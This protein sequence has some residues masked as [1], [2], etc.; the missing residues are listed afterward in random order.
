M[1]ENL[2]KF[3]SK[4]KDVEIIY[5]PL[6]EGDIPHSLASIQK[7]ELLLNYNPKFS[8]AEGLKEAVGWYWDNLK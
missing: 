5:G 8:L 6:R 1:K 4:I 2:S 3:D 7:A